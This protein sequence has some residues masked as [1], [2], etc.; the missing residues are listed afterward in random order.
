MCYTVGMTT[1]QKK[2]IHRSFRVSREVYE[3]ARRR[4]QEDGVSI[5]SAITELL[6]GYANNIYQLPKKETIKIYSSGITTPSSLN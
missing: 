5:S 4:A 3:S 1:D 2:E 6:E